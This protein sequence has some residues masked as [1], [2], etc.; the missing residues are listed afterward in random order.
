M[1]QHY[2][3]DLHATETGFRIPTVQP[4]AADSSAAILEEPF[5]QP[6]GKNRQKI[7][8]NLLGVE[9]GYDCD[10]ELSLIVTEAR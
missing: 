3:Y 10:H 8:R 7:D 4:N 1:P 9:S 5:N 2:D 6:D